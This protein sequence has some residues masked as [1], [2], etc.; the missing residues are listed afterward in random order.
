MAIDDIV[1]EM[2]EISDYCNS[3][4]LKSYLINCV[5]RTANPCNLEEKADPQNQN[6]FVKHLFNL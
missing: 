6:S 2:S 4:T 5:S 3:S 1:Y